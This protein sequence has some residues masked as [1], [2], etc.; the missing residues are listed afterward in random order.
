MNKLQLP[1]NTS[2]DADSTATQVM[3]E[4]DLSGKLAVVT[5]GYAGLG[6][7]TVKVL[8]TAGASVVVPVRDLDKA[9][10]ALSALENVQVSVMDLADPDSIDAFA[11]S[12]NQQGK[13]IDLLINNAG[14]MAMPLTR[15]RRGYEMQLAINH[16]GHFQLTARLWPS[17]IKASNPRVVCLT[18]GAH[19]FSAVDFDDPHYHQR[20]YSAWQAYGQS[21]TAN[22]LFA[23]E[24]NRRAKK[25]PVLAFSVH[26]GSITD[27]DLSRHLSLADMQAMGF[28]DESGNIPE[29]SKYLYKSV[30]Q[31]AATT[32]WCATSPLL[33]PLG[34]VYCEDCNIAQAVPGDWK[35]RNGVL[36]WA[37]DAE[38]AERL[39][40]LTEAQTGIDFKV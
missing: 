4:T 9:R 40:Q 24:L 14:V 36:P 20:P 5:G 8:V 2:F 7:E 11:R 1:I 17:I 16:F 32:I 28:R 30:E 25:Y 39:W 23:L 3:G 10:K 6:L 18:S 22:A 33:E 13:P 19:R 12:L 29:N 35:E 26:P 37:C 15:D 27:T 34:G 38:N 21:K 31:G